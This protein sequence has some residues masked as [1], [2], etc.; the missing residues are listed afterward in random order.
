MIDTAVAENKRSIPRKRSDP[1]RSRQVMAD[2]VQPLDAEDREIVEEISQLRREREQDE[3]AIQSI[4]IRHLERH[5]A[6]RTIDPLDP[7]IMALAE[8]IRE[9][10]QLD[11]LRVRQLGKDR[12][13]IISGER[14]YTAI[15]VHLDPFYLV[16]CIVVNIDDAAALRE[17]AVANSNREDLNPVQRAELM[18]QL[19][20]PKDKGGSGL[21]LTDAGK[22]FG[23]SSESG[24]KNALRILKLPEKIRA[25]VVSG[26]LPERAARTLVPYS[27][28][29]KALDEVAKDLA[30]DQ[31]SRFELSEGDI[32]WC[33]RSFLLKNTR[34]ISEDVKRDY[35]WPLGEHPC[36]FDWK[37]HQEQ[38]NIIE[39]PHD[40]NDWRNS[41]KHNFQPRRFATNVKLWDKLQS[42]H[43][44]E[45]EE[46]Q[47]QKAAKGAK[48][49]AGKEKKLTPAE[50]AAEAKRK[51]KESNEQLDRFSREWAQRLFRC[52]IAGHSDNEDLVA[53]TWPW[54]VGQC[55]RSDLCRFHEQAFVECQV[56]RPKAVRSQYGAVDTLPY[57]AMFNLKKNGPYKQKIF[58]IQNAFWRLL[59]WPVS[60]LIAEGN[61]S[62]LTPAGSLPDKLPGYI[63]LDD[64]KALA[65][66][67]G[68]SIESAWKAGT[69]D[70]SDERRLISA[71]LMRHTIAQLQAL[72]TE[73][74]TGGVPPA[75]WSSRAPLAN[76]ILTAH[77]PGKPLPVPKRL[78]KLFK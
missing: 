28:L 61:K 78:Q 26:E 36:L 50:E 71:W 62:T 20:K 21:S 59:L 11:P 77:K 51:A 39:L 9:N 55:D 17:V 19:M 10:G 49:A 72:T 33:L 68:V 40:L 31:R 29:P 2:R 65:V 8:S 16:R 14:R 45:L 48:K 57:L 15:K 66:H 6:N 1:L 60:H 75:V 23:L 34:P 22:L 7:S 43:I 32:P 27:A 67:A 46:K 42:P 25:M 52:A 63:D 5:P 70:S 4:L 41:G 53:L 69:V 3:R 37:P 18:Q 38:L 24:S 64:L 73:L 74:P 44:K 54:I 47:K 76:H 58:N 56:D 30:K 35:H 13:Q 12:Y